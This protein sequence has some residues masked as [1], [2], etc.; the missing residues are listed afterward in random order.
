MHFGF[1]Y[2]AK[3]MAEFMTEIASKNIFGSTL[4]GVG[5]T[6]AI[7]PNVVAWIPSDFGA[8]P[9]RARHFLKRKNH[10]AMP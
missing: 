10:A 9:S 1:K 3:G 2:A 4:L 7:S 8:S 6:G 5:C